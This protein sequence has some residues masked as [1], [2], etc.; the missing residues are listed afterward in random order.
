V[1]KGCILSEIAA[2]TKNTF[3]TLPNPIATKRTCRLNLPCFQTACPNY[4][5]NLQQYKKSNINLLKPKL[6]KLKENQA[7]PKP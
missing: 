1:C 4:P 5:R 2:N 6:K 3:I 7:E